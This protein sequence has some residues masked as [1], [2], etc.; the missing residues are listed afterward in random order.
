MSSDLK[1]RI[2]ADLNEA[3]RQRDKE[4]TLVL[5]TILSDLKNRE[6]EAGGSLADDDAVQV[7]AKAIK[8]RRDASDQMRD[9]GREELAAV[10]DAQAAV[11]QGYL[12]EGLTE[13]EVRAMI[14][15]IVAGGATAMG[16]VMGQLMPRIRGRFDGKEANRVVKEELDG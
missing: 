16:A 13:E 4:R 10:E 6:L 3:R 9:A 15:E 12:P 2:Q 11:L 7:I 8:Q 14:R 5:S 1:G